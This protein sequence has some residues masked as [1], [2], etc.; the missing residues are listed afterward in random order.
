MLSQSPRVRAAI[1][2]S[3]SGTNARALCAYA[4]ANA[5]GYQVCLVIATKHDI[6]IV[7]VAQQFGVPCVICAD[8]AS[9]AEDVCAAINNHNIELLL[10]AGLLRHVASSIVAAVNG[11]VLNIHPSLLP[12]HGGKGMYGL[13]VHQAVLDAGDAMTGATVHLVTNEYDQ[14]RVIAQA[15]VPVIQGETAEQL[16]VRVKA[17]E[18]QLYGPAVDKF[19]GELNQPRPSSKT[20]LEVA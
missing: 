20:P 19:C 10:L 18:H 12:K 15:E 17:V 8:K 14:G 9:F 16:Q 3:G 6:G 4:A 5:S 1:I 2:G 13:H 7:D 11:N